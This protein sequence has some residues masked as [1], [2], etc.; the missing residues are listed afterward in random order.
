M[1]AQKGKAV[2]TLPDT[3][4]E[5]GDWVEDLLYQTISFSGRTAKFLRE[6]NAR[7]GRMH[8][9][10]SKRPMYHIEQATRRRE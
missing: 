2:V 3:K 6:C 10:R 8:Y 5:L 1:S 7:G 4:V 9:L